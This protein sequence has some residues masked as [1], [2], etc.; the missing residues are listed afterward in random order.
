MPSPLTVTFIQ[1]TILNIIAN[2]LA[3]LIDQYKYAH[4]NN[5]PF[6]FTLNTPALIQFTIYGIIVVPIN[7]EWQKYIEAKFPGFPRPT[8]GRARSGF[9]RAFSVL[10]APFRR[11]S[12]RFGIGEEHAIDAIELLPTEERSFIAG[13]GSSSSP[14]SSGM[15]NFMAKFVLDQ[16]VGSVVNIVLFIVLINWL[17]GTSAGA[18]LG[19]VKEDFYPIMLARLAYRPVVS[20]LMY[21]VV[22]MEKR[23]VFGS[24]SGVV[25]GVYLSLYAAV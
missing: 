19:L 9:R 13:H 25:W 22:P 17:K 18:I 11:G 3:Q 23:V 6:A 20:A 10:L 8:F 4:R 5:K 24:A 1:S 21:T 12:S 15:R 14:S 2:V 16:T 7:F